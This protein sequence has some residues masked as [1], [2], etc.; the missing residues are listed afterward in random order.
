MIVL[1]PEHLQQ[2]VEAG[3]A[4]YPEESCGLLIGQG[5]GGSWR[6][7]RV[8]PSPNLAEADRRRRFEVDPR[9]LIELQRSLRHGPQRLIGVFH[10]HP[11]QGP[12][13]SAT[14]LE[15]AREPGQVWLITSVLGGQAAR[16]SAHVLAEGGG[17]FFQIPLKTANSG[18]GKPS[19]P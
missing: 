17:R 14:D 3:E 2:I 13:P 5:E 1:L 18:E 12:E 4:A 6:V 10:S 7:A 15:Q 19:H 11:D 9:L 16:T 8:A